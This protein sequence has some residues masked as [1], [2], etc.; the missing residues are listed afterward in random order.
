MELRVSQSSFGNA[1]ERW[2]RNDAA[3]G[4]RNA[5]ALVIGHDQEDIGRAL[6]RH[7]ARRPPWRR[8]LRAFLDHAPKRH[9]WRRELLPVK[10]HGG[11]GRTRYAVD[12]LLRPDRR[13]KQQREDAD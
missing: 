4:A 13:R 5:V 6:G 11:V 10:R 8:I 3:E 1:I 2:R 7:Y 9:Q 12:L